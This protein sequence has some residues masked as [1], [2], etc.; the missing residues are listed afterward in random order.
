MPIPWKMDEMYTSVPW[1]WDSVL[2][3][4]RQVKEMGQNHSLVHNDTNSIVEQTLAKNDGVEFR[5]DLVLVEYG[6]DGDRV[7]C[8][9]RGSEDEAFN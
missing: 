5:V 7:R 4:Q 3:N 9:Q 8:G 6:Q 1:N 2:Q